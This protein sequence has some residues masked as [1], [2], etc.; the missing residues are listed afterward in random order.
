MSPCYLHTT[1]T[2]NVV[3][4]I[5]QIYCPSSQL[6]VLLVELDLLKRFLNFKVKLNSWDW[7][8]KDW[9]LFHLSFLPEE[10]QQFASKSC[11]IKATGR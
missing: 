10:T 3:L 5:S 7:Q 11:R 2:L 8:I 4:I 1:K 9:M 6:A